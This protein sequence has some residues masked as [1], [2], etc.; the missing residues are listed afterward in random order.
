M[1]STKRRLATI[2]KLAAMLVPLALA[3]W[4]FVIGLG[5]LQSKELGQE[6]LDNIHQFVFLIGELLCG[7]T[8][9]SGILVVALTYKENEAI[10]EAWRAMVLPIFLT[11]GF[12]GAATIFPDRPSRLESYKAQAQYNLSVGAKPTP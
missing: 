6:G 2:G 5:V 10:K 12:L 7:V 9:A 3:T 4:V 11:V 8:I 1:Q